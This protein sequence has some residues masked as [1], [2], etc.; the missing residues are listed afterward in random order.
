L[1]FRLYSIDNITFSTPA[2]IRRNLFSSITSTNIAQRALT[3]L[4]EKIE[5]EPA[6]FD[7]T[8]V[9]EMNIHKR[10]SGLMKYGQKELFSL[11]YLQK[12]C[13]IISDEYKNVKVFAEGKLP[14]RQ[15]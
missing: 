2:A 3:S 1:L 13:S 11:T 6:S 14:E 10:Q 5:K 7:S 8:L 15:M 12:H 4:I 9:K